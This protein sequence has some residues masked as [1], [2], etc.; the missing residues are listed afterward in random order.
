MAIAPRG[1]P[2][3]G[4]TCSSWGTQ[5]AGLEL[6]LSSATSKSG[7]VRNG[8]GG[9]TIRRKL[10]VLKHIFP[11]VF[12]FLFFS[13]PFFFFFGEVPARPLPRLG[14][15][16]NAVRVGGTGGASTNTEGGTLA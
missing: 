8:G 9:G 15:D 10:P 2:S 11:W 6:S 3:L 13:F 1:L 7:V 14:R 4:R 12:L 5:R 16:Q